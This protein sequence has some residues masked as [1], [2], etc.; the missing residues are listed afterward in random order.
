MIISLA[1]QK[2]GVGKTTSC[3]NLAAALAAKN[4]KV[5]IVDLDPQGNT[6][7]GLGFFRDEIKNTSYDLLING[8]SA[9]ECICD[10]GRK[11]LWICPCNIDLAGAEV[12]LVEKE[13]REQ[14]LK[15]SLSPVADRYDEIFIDCPPSLG[16]LTVNALTA[17]DAVL[18]PVQ[19]EYY[20]LEGLSQLLETIAFV[21][22]N[23]NPQLEIFGAL[24]TMVDSRTQLAKQVSEEVRKFFKDKTF[25]QEIPRNIRLSEAPSHAK[26]IFEYER[27]SKGAR[28]YANV[29]KEFLK[30]K[31]NFKQDKSS[32]QINE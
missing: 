3:I 11:N 14:I 32:R 13:A 27:W 18:I 12:E 4:E 24:L 16:L 30:W 28:A 25:R 31:K 20:A 1:N 15:Q 2:G 22:K 9:E 26:T 7:S 8:L 10:T 17:S 23:T 6:S 29:A 19:A 21:K 5:L